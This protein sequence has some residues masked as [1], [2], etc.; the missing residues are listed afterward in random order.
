LAQF[1]QNAGQW[2]KRA[3]SYVHN[4]VPSKIDKDTKYERD[5]LLLGIGSLAWNIMRSKAPKEI[6]DSIEASIDRSQMLREMQLENQKGINYSRV[7][8]FF[9]IQYL[10]GDTGYKIQIEG[11]EYRFLTATQAPS[12]GYIAQD[13]VSYVTTLL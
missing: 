9:T 11:K 1:G 12:E 10:E 8:K 3:F 2:H 13:Y 5:S 4:F 7:Q 6:V